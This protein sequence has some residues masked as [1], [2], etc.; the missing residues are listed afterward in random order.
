VFTIGEVKKALPAVYGH[1]ARV[2]VI[3]PE[4]GTFKYDGPLSEAPD[5]MET[6]VDDVTRE[7]IDQYERRVILDT[8]LAENRG[9]GWVYLTDTYPVE[10]KYSHYTKPFATLAAAMAWFDA[11]ATEDEKEPQWFTWT[12]ETSYQGTVLPNQWV[13][14]HVN[15]RN[16]DN[17]DVDIP[18]IYA[19][20]IGA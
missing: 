20:K 9:A 7:M 17:Y 6:R 5:D 11:D 2:K 1:S 13:A 3:D 12:Q 19:A 18:K 8:D 4:T 16:L 15:G 14:T 10:S